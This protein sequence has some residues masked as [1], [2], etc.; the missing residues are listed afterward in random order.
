[1]EDVGVIGVTIPAKCC[2]GIKEKQLLVFLWQGSEVMDER[3][4]RIRT[5]L[6]AVVNFGT[7]NGVTV[8]LREL[9]DLKS[10][11]VDLAELASIKTQLETIT[12]QRDTK[13][14]VILDIS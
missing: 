8:H 3:I 11:E 5:S 6:A 10:I 2:R 13:A 12:K 4:E 14:A 1:M 9:D 7:T